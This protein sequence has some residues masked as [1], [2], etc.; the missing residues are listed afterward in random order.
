MCNRFC[1]TTVDDVPTEKAELTV[2]DEFSSWEPVDQ[3]SQG[4]CGQRKV[5]TLAS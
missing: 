2:H 3:F 5:G 1:G 4:L